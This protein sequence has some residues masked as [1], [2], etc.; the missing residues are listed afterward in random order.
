MPERL[1]T[2]NFCVP[3]FRLDANEKDAKL[4]D[5]VW[6][7]DSVSLVPCDSLVV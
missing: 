6:P 4:F 7:L 1:S 3:L 5:S 2:E